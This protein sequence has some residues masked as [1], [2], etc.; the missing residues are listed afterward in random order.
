MRTTEERKVWGQKDREIL[1][2]YGMVVVLSDVIAHQ[3]RRLRVLEL[4]LLERK[5][6]TLEQ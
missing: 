2:L 5:C 4:E 1:D 3:N 6:Q